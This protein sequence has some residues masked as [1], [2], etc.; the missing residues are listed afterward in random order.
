[1][2]RFLIN[3]IRYPGL[4]IDIGARLNILGTF[5]Y[6]YQCT[7]GEGTIIS[8]PTNSRFSLGHNN[9]LGRYV[10]VG[11]SS[12]IVLGDN[13]SVQDRCTFLGDIH[14]GRYC[15]FAPNVFISSGRHYYDL[16]PDYLIKDQDDIVLND[17]A[18]RRMH[19][20][21]VV[22]E[23][24][25][26][27]GANVVVM[28]GVLISKGSVVGA[29]SVVTKDI[30]PYAVVA[31]APAQIIKHR[32]KFFPPQHIDSQNSHDI[33]YFY[34][35]FEVDST[36]QLKYAEFKGLV[37]RQDFILCLN[38]SGKK[39]VRLL[40]RILSDKKG[41]LFFGNQKQPV[42]DSFEE[43]CFLIDDDTEIK[44]RFR[45]ELNGL[46][47]LLIIKMAWVQ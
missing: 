25:C 13:S 43:I 4:T 38:P 3:R 20:R 11:V 24:D 30:P 14:I 9:Y 18:M 17:H 32:L 26:W 45:A 8:V 37:C 19:S 5:S 15:L 39:S 22:I 28:P 12:E 31:G 36:S 35:G 42:S 1:M 33:P 21:P 41:V 29:N 16:R 6:Q 2:V 44:L 23:D 27:L 10:E 40:A 34:S 47:D 7:V 46:N